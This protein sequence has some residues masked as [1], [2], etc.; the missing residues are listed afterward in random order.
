MKI[1]DLKEIIRNV[2]DDSERFI[3][4][5]LEYPD[6]Y[7]NPQYKILDDGDLLLY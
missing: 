5:N 6:V 4:Q 3:L 2:N 1:K 7:L